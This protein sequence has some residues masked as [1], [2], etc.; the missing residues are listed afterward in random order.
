MSLGASAISLDKSNITLGCDATLQ[1][2][3]N[4][5]MNYTST[6]RQ[7]S[8]ELIKSVKAKINKENLY[9]SLKRD[10]EFHIITNKNFK[11]YKKYVDKVSG[12]YEKNKNDIE[13][14][15]ENLKIELKDFIADMNGFEHHQSELLEERDMMIKT[16]NAILEHKMEEQKKLKEQ[17]QKVSKDLAEQTE[18]L[19]GVN[20]RLDE[21]TKEEEKRREQLNVFEKD[22]IDKYEELKIKMKVI[23]NRFDYYNNIEMERLQEKTDEFQKEKEEQKNEEEIDM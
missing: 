11:Q 5:I 20:K 4:N 14:Y 2:I 13:N 6:N 1:K 15:C 22:E 3:K 7:R 10:L 12:Y 16:N 21:L 23:Q 8:Q 9:Q 19:D 17:L 18:V